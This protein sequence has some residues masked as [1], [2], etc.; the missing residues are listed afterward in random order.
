MVE[1]NGSIR[2]CHT[3]YLGMFVEDY[4]TGFKYD[5]IGIDPDKR[6]AIAV[7]SKS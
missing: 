4:Y 6:E 5:L 7:R 2:V 3:D 1:A